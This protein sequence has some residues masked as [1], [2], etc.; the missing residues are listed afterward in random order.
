MKTSGDEL[1]HSCSK[2]SC[3]QLFSCGYKLRRSY[4]STRYQVIKHYSKSNHLA[5]VTRTNSFCCN[6]LLPAIAQLQTGHGNT[7]LPPW[8]Y[9]EEWPRLLLLCSTPEFLG[10][11]SHHLPWVF[12]NVYHM[13]KISNHSNLP[14]FR[15]SILV[16][17]LD[18]FHMDG[19]G[20]HVGFLFDG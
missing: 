4:E 9:W 13:L 1:L 20:C 18:L 8:Q 15:F 12:K 17:D 2:R 11:K 10:I 6:L 7:T 16:Q 3:L 5:H 19:L 14:Q